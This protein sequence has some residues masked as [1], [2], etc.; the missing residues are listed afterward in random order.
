MSYP[1]WSFIHCC[2][3]VVMCNTSFLHCT[4]KCLGLP[5]WYVS[6]LHSRLR[7]ASVFY[8]HFQMIS[9]GVHVTKEFS[10][11]SPYSFSP[12]Q[13]RCCFKCKSN[14]LILTPFSLS[15]G[16]TSWYYLSELYPDKIMKITISKYIMVHHCELMNCLFQWLDVI[17]S[18]LQIF[19]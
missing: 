1:W 6:H 15:T 4:I 3:L 7:M 5:D 13:R 9:N 11:L 19:N 16:S 14:Y 8:P 18:E 17:G 12:K 2:A 10:P